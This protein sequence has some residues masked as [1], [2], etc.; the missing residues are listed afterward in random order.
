MKKLVLKEIS[1]CDSVK[2]LT[3]QWCS[4]LCHPMACSPPGSFAHGVLQA[5]ILEWVAIPFS[6]RPSW[7]RDQTPVSYIAG[8]FFTFWTDGKVIQWIYVKARF[9]TLFLFTLKPLQYCKIISLQLIKINE[10][11]NKTLIFLLYYAHWY[12]VVVV[13]KRESDPPI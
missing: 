9:Q 5:R 8:G 4:T 1:C 13:V 7:P 3:T 11:K 6:R 2:V 12:L 10:K